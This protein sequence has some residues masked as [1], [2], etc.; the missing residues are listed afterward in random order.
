RAAADATGRFVVVWSGPDS[1]EDGIFG[2]RFDAA[3]APAGAQF[4]VNTYTSGYQTLPA[5]AM[6][7]DGR[8]VVAWRSDAEIVAR[9]FDVQGN[10]AGPAFEVS[11]S[12]Y[13]QGYP[14]VAMQPAGEFMVSWSSYYQ[15]A[16]GT[17]GVQARVFDASGAPRGAE[18]RLN[19]FVAS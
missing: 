13:L 17:W 10:P 16:P 6:A 8:F 2:Q 4:Q 1:S 9:R 3:G 18:F 7:D 12:A 5:V 19:Q 15:D 11:P 14:A